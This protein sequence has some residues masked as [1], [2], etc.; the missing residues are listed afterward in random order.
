MMIISVDY[1][2]SFQTIAF[3]HSPGDASAQKHSQ[4]SDGAEAGDSLVLDVAEW[5]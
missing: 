4:G 5:L 1:H 3:L 2:P